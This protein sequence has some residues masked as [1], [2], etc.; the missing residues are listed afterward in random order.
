M[1]KEANLSEEEY[2]GQIIKACF[3]DEEN[4]VQKW[5]EVNDM[6]QQKRDILTDMKIEYVHVVGPDEDLRVRI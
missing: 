4:P 2:R 6:I 1:A 5:R 3:L